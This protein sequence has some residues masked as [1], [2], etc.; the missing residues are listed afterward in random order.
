MVFLDR[1][2]TSE[3]YSMFSQKKET[4][5]KRSRSKL[6]DVSWYDFS[7]THYRWK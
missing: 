7:V 5:F 2:V 4:Y 1:T 3:S 6:Y